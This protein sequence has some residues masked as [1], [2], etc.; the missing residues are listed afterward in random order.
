MAADLTRTGRKI[1]QPTGYR[2][3]LPHP[4]PYD[5]PLRYDDGLQALLSE[6]DQALARLDVATEFL[7]NPDL[8]VGMYVRKEAVL[9]SQ[10]EGTQASLVAMLTGLG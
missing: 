8:F 6:A 3:F 4:L 2:A 7:P 9:S 5:P 10:I 1:L